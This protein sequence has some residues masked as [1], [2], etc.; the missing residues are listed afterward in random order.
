MEIGKLYLYKEMETSKPKL[1]V[2]ISGAYEVNGRISNFWR[3]KYITKKG[4]ISK[5]GGG[6]YNNAK[7]KFRYIR[8]YTIKFE[9]KEK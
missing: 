7:Y 1:V 2:V 6:D 5:R 4:Y 8:G 9:L 3:F